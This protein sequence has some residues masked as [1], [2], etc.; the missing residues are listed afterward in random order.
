MV[1]GSITGTRKGLKKLRKL[2]SLPRKPSR[3]NQQQT[4]R[5]IVVKWEKKH[6][7]LLLF[8]ADSRFWQKVKQ[9]NNL[10]H[11][12]LLMWLCDTVKP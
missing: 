12:L 3:F 5:A 10:H 7:Y 1:A 6:A 8:E 9:N 2:L 11:F 4:N